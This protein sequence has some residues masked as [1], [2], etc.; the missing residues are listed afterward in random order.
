MKILDP[1]EKKIEVGK[2]V[3][4]NYQGEVRMGTVVDIVKVKRHG[5]A[6]DWSGEPYINI[7]VE[8]LTSK[9]ISKVSSRKNLVVIEG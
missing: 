6:K 2:N 7:L 1:Y 8:E 4:Y 3:A 9:D 5:K